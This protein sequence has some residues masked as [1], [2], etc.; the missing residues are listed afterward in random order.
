M[1]HSA[2]GSMFASVVNNKSHCDKNYSTALLN[3]QIYRNLPAAWIVTI[4]KSSN[5]ILNLHII[6]AAFNYAID[7]RMLCND[8]IHRVPFILIGR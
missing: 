6:T 5:P 4:A 7:P 2:L 3:H 8:T 1:R